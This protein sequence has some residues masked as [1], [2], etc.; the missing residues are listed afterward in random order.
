MTPNPSRQYGIKEFCLA[1]VIGLALLFLVREAWIPKNGIMLV[2]SIQGDVFLP[3][4]SSR[5]WPIGEARHCEIASHGSIPP[6]DRGDLLLCDYQTKFAWS[7]TWLR[8]DIRSQIYDA[9]TRLPVRFHN[10]GHGLGARAPQWWMCSRTAE[11]I[12]CK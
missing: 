11:G 4:I 2:A 3:R 5:Y 6:D 12:D 1:F 10:I 7:Q 9:A 8:K